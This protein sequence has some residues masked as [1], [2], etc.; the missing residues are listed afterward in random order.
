VFADFALGR[1]VAQSFDS[2][3]ALAGFLNTDACKGFA[4]VGGDQDVVPCLGEGAG[5]AVRKGDPVVTEFNNAIQAIRADG[6]Y[7][8]FNDAYFAID[9]YGK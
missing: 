4:F 2:L 3:L 7:K 1:L 6:T 8:K 9:V 5:I